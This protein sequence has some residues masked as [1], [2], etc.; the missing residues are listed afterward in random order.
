MG[1]QPVPT[2]HLSLLLA[3]LQLGLYKRTTVLHI[4]ISQNK[5]SHYQTTAFQCIAL[6]DVTSKSHEQ[7]LITKEGNW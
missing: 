4:S 2:L 3:W 1:Y 7:R 5:L 6:N